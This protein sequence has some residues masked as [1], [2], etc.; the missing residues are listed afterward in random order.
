MKERERKKHWDTIYESKKLEETSWFQLNPSASLKFIEELDLSKTAS[1][2]DVGGGESLLV[3][4]LLEQGFEDITVLDISA[5]AIAKAKQRLGAKSVLV[6]WIISDITTFEPNR[7]Y[8]LWHD[9]A[10]FHFLNS[11]TD[12]SKYVEIAQKAVNSNAFMIIGTFSEKGP[13]RCSGL[14][15]KQYSAFGLAD[16][17]SNSFVKVRCTSLNHK[18]PTGA[19][20]NFVFCS[21]RKS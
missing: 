1:I 4:R 14:E 20:Q 12:I 11:E 8:D 13:D 21:F 5:V 3:D 10:T 7:K 9:R 18:T 6:N 16:L 15:I 19:L 17:F 2:I